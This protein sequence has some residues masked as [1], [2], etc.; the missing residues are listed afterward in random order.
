M[1][2]LVA[3]SAALTKTCATRGRPGYEPGR[4]NL[5][6]R[7]GR[8]HTDE[9]REQGRGPDP[10]ERADVGLEPGAGGGEVEKLAPVEPLRTEYG[11]RCA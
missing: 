7:E 10:D 9:R 5:A 3:D 6:E 8:R 1:P 2:M 4:D 11:R